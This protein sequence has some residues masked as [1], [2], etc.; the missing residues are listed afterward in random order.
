MDN[1]HTRVKSWISQ[2]RTDNGEGRT[3]AWGTRKGAVTNKRNSKYGLEYTKMNLS[4]WMA[5]KFFEFM[6]EHDLEYLAHKHPSVP[7]VD[8]IEGTRQWPGTDRTV[9]EVA[10]H[11][12]A[13]NIINFPWQTKMEG[14]YMSSVWYQLQQIVNSGEYNQ[15]VN[16]GPMDWSYHF[17]HIYDLDN[18]L[19]FKHPMQGTAKF[20]MLIAFIIKKI[21]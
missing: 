15:T 8:P 3:D 21:T 19:L 16:G 6:H 7:L 2:K 18:I 17:L 9:F 13:Y 10:P 4:K 20:K 1:F 5:V 11:F 14:K 12:T